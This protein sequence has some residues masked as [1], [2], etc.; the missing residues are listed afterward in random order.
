[1]AWLSGYTYRKKG[2][3]NATTAGAQTLYQ[4]KLIV[5]ESS[6]AAGCDVHCENHC[7][8]FPND[9]RFT[10][11]DGETK[12]DYW[13]EEITGTTPNR[14]A[15][16]WIEVASIPVS[17]SVDFYMYY[18]KTSDSGE[19]SGDNTFEFFDDFDT[20]PLFIISGLVTSPESS[21]IRT[22]GGQY[23]QA[24]SGTAYKTFTD[25]II[26]FRAKFPSGKTSN[27]LIGFGSSAGTSPYAYFSSRSSGD[28]IRAITDYNDGSGLEGTTMEGGG[29]LDYDEDGATT[30]TPSISTYWMW[31]RLQ[32]T[33]GAKKLCVV[34]A[35][36]GGGTASNTVTCKI[37]DD[38]AGE[39][40]TNV[41][42]TVT[43]A[44]W[45]AGW[46]TFEFSSPA[47]LLDNQYF[48]VGI[49]TTTSSCSWSAHVKAGA[50][51][52]YCT[53]ETT[54]CSAYNYG[55]NI[56]TYTTTGDTCPP[57]D[58]YLDAYHTFK[59]IRDATSTRFY[60]DGTL[61]ATHRA[62]TTT[63]MR[64][65]TIGWG[66]NYQDVDWIKYYNAS[67]V[68]QWTED[69]D[70]FLF[71]T[72]GA[73][74]AQV[75]VSTSVAALK[76]LGAL[77]GGKYITLSKPFKLNT[78]LRARVKYGTLDVG[79]NCKH[80]AGGVSSA[81]AEGIGT[82]D[83]IQHTSIGTDGDDNINRIWCGNGSACTLIT[84]DNFHL[85]WTIQEIQRLT[86]KVTY[87]QAT[88]T[89]EVTTNVMQGDEHVVMHTCT[90][91]TDV[92]TDW[93]LVRKY[94][95]P[96]PTW[97][98]WG[99]ES[100]GVTPKTSSDVG[101]GV[102]ALTSLSA[103]LTQ[104]DVGSGAESLGSRAL[105]VR[106]VGSGID[107]LSELIATI[108]KSDQGAG[109]DAAIA[110]INIIQKNDAGAGADAL[111]SLLAAI[112]QSDIGSGAES[113]SSRAFGAVDQGAGTDALSELI[114][115]V[116]KSDSGAGVDALSELIATVLK[117]DSGAGVDALSEL[118]ATILK[119][120]SG[121]GAD[122]LSEL[123]ASIT[124][125]DSGTGVD[126]LSELLATVI[127][128][129]SGS[130]IEVAIVR[131]LI[132]LKLLQESKINIALSQEAT[133]K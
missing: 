58:D 18:R 90:T 111:T 73:G 80:A 116:L 47:E 49:H 33:G 113:V 104:S 129:D 61:K 81:G 100:G 56:K 63:A 12:H 95:S 84:F 121:A 118:I 11:E 25:G 68:L 107:A 31:H 16:V 24:H 99:G 65:T 54:G 32:N 10:K 4:L 132:L 26:E 50:I 127:R 5:G 115:T 35:K 38:N 28:A 7:L 85:D 46:N 59:I 103:I 1:M 48:W 69:F 93:V 36:S 27:T 2:A 34:K 78:A 133:A 77:L 51:G 45:G 60:V 131:T 3:V 123:L 120:D 55:S 64:C 102:D 87:K 6:G 105:G 75:I 44:D 96:E 101:S 110:L 126:A 62:D 74:S 19:S 88:E 22:T 23:A 70:K 117:S 43:G 128:S 83:D 39:I 79:D 91:Y 82:D 57:L 40:G 106:E 94:A 52:K 71:H 9:I 53:G 124:K 37:R 41:L 13:I 119:S 42:A 125:S 109:I 30:Y 114:A 76:S 72:F 14:K 20:Q 92:K 97:G 112:T 8:D 122:A 108:L 15:T 21:V 86:N 130:G 29:T 98:S 66:N 17:G 67:E 89:K